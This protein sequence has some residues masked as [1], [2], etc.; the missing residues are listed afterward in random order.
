ME[1]WTERT[2]ALGAIL[3]TDSLAVYD[4]PSD[5]DLEKCKDFGIACANA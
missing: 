5:E 4:D 3:V 1:E 2:K